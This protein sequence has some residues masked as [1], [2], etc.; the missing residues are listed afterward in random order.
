MSINSYSQDQTEKIQNTAKN[1]AVQLKVVFLNTGKIGD[2]NLHSSSCDDK[3]LDNEAIQAARKIS[4]NPQI[5]DGKPITVT[6]TVEYKFYVFDEKAEAIIKKAVEQLGGA[7]YLNVKTQVGRGKFSVLREGAVISFQSFLDVI[8]F[9]DKERTE[10][11]SG[12]SKIVQTNVGETGWI[13][14]G[15]AQTVKDQKPDQIANFKRGI[16][17]S[18]DNLLRGSWRGDATLSYVGKRQATLGKRNDVVK[19]VYT[20]DLTVEF[21]FSDEGL[22]VKAIY[23]LMNPDNEEVTQEDRYAQFIEVQGIKAPFIIDR[24]SNGQPSSRI[25]YESIE[26]D[27]KISDSIFTKPANAKEA[28]KEVKL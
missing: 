7:R 25:N 24:F 15:E 27:K 6:K 26:Y 11:K 23:K 28:K 5:N 8:V 18:L 2:V 12:G 4:F 17:V 19:L 14:D 9:P 16:R 10:F 1:C 22:P 13:F 21:E 20:D 3:K